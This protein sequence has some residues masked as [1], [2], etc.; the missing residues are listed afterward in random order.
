MLR[1]TNAFSAARLQGITKAIRRR[2]GAS[3][4]QS[5][6]VAAGEVHL[7]LGENGAGKSTLMKIVA[8]MLERD[9]GRMLWNGSEVLLRRPPK[10]RAIGIA[11][12]HQESLLAPHMTVA[13]NIF[14]GREDARRWAG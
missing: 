10:P 3:R 13:E 8:G 6:A 4:R 12:V 11:M 5:L 2:H 9:A 7:L 1:Y 14:L